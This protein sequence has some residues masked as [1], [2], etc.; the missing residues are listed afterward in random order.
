MQIWQRFL[1]VSFLINV[2]FISALM[3]LFTLLTLEVHHTPSQASNAVMP[4]R[5]APG[6]LNKGLCLPKPRKINK[7]EP[8][9]LMPI[10]G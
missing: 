7:S 5:K 8:K 9:R 4:I 10:I 2:Y 3:I 1:S 6:I